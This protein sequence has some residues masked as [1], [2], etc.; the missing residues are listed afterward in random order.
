MAKRKEKQVRHLAALLAASMI[1]P[2]A[3]PAIRV[4]ADEPHIQGE[5]ATSSGDIRSE[6]YVEEDRKGE[7]D[8]NL[9]VSDI[10][11]KEWDGSD[12]VQC[13]IGLTGIRAGC[14]NVSLQNYTLR[15]EDSDVGTGKSVIVEKIILGGEDASHYHL[16]QEQYYFTSD[17][18]ITKRKLKLSG[19]VADRYY[20]EGNTDADINVKIENVAMTDYDSSKA[21]LIPGNL[22]VSVKAHFA[23]EHAGEGKKVTIDEIMLSGNHAK[24]YIVD[25]QFGELTGTIRKAGRDAPDLPY[26][27]LAITGTDTTMEWRFNAGGWSDCG[28]CIVLDGKGTYEVRYKETDDY[29][30]S[31]PFRLTLENSVKGMED[32]SFSFEEGYSPVK[33]YDGTVQAPSRVSWSGPAAGDQVELVSYTASYEQ[34]EVGEEILVS[35]TDPVFSGKDAD[36]YNTYFSG[37]TLAT[38]YGRITPR[39]IHV[40]VAATDKDYDGTRKANVYICGHTS[41]VGNENPDLTV[42]GEFTDADAGEGKAVTYGQVTLSGS[43]S[44]NY[45]IGKVAPARI[46]DGA[47]KELESLTATIRKA[48]QNAPDKALFSVKDG[49]LMGFTSDMEVL[50]PG[51]TEYTDCKGL[52]EIMISQGSSYLFRYKESENYKPG[53]T[54]TVSVGV[55]KTV[56]ITFDLNGA[57]VNGT[58]PTTATKT[59]GQMYGDILMDLTLADPDLEF[60]GWFTKRTGGVQVIPGDIC[61]R[62]EDFTLYAHVQEKANNR[63]K[64]EIAVSIFN[65]VYGNRISPQVSNVTGD[66]GSYTFYYKQAAEDD[67]AYTLEKPYRPGAYV[68]K[69]VA[70]KTND[71]DT[72]EATAEFQITKRILTATFTPKSRP[73][74]GLTSCEVEGN[75]SIA[76][77]IMSWDGRKDDVALSGTPSINFADKNVGNNKEVCLSGLSLTGSDADFYELHCET[78]TA[79]IT[80]YQLEYQE[81]RLDQEDRNAFS[82]TAGNKVYDQNTEAVIAAGLTKISGDDV[83]IK[84]LGRF[85]DP[86]AGTDKEVAVTS[87]TLEGA[88][89]ANYE[90]SYPASLVLKAIIYKAANENY[91]DISGTNPVMGKKNGTITGLTSAMEY[92]TDGGTLWN[93]CP[94]G[95]LAGLAAGEYRIRFSETQN[96][97]ASGV[98]IVVLK[99][100]ST[101][102]KEDKTQGQIKISID[103]LIYGETNTSPEVVNVAGDYSEYIFYYKPVGKEDEAYSVERPEIPGKYM[104]KA[105]AKETEK[106]KETEATEEFTIR[107]RN[108]PVTVVSSK[109]YDGTTDVN[110][111]DCNWEN[112]LQKDQESVGVDLSSAE[113]SYMDKYAGTEKELS[114]RGLRIIGEKADCYEI[115]EITG[116]GVI[117]KRELESEITADEKEYDGTRDAVLS[118]KLTNMVKGDEVTASGKALFESPLPGKEIPVSVTEIILEGKDAANYELK[119]NRKEI[120]GTIRN[121]VAEVKFDLNG[122]SSLTGVPSPIRIEAGS[123]YPALPYVVGTDSSKPFLGWFTAEGIH[124]KEG[125]PYQGEAVLYARFGV[126]SEGMIELSAKSYEYGEEPNIIVRILSGNYK[127]TDIQYRYRLKAN[128][129]WH[130]GLPKEPGEYRIQAIV[131]GNDGADG[132]SAE[133]DVLVTKRKITLKAESIEK[134]YDGNAKA[135]SV[136]QL[137]GILSEDKVKV[138]AD[139]VY[140][141]YKPGDR[142]VQVTSIKLTGPDASKYILSSNTYTFPGVIRKKVGSTVTVKGKNESLYGKHDG[143]IAG[144]SKEMEYRNVE[145]KTWITCPDGS[146]TGL[147]NGTYEIRMKETDISAPGSVQTVTIVSEKT[148]GMTVVQ[149]DGSTKTIGIPY[150][151]KIERPADPV[152]TGYSFAGWYKDK[153]LTQKWDFDHGIVTDHVTLY[154]KWI[155]RTSSS[156]S[157]SSSRSSG[158]SGGGSSK[159]VSS[160]PGAVSG[161]WEKDTAGHWR[162][163]GSHRYVNEWAYIANPYADT[164]KGQEGASW[165]HFGHDGIMDTGWFTD[166]DGRIY[167]LNPISD[168]TLG[169]MLTGWHWLRGQDGLLRCYYFEEKSNGYRGMLYQGTTTP[170]GYTVDVDGAWTVGGIVVTRE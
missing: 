95:E 139:A 26:S 73:Y 144:V 142:T 158:S 56:A 122:E 58:Y 3:V 145:N 132:I 21:S 130:S 23:D 76:G 149:P 55:T 7:Y 39:T 97:R 108:I 93:R 123:P 8:L 88:D 128:D 170:D 148:I 66:Y 47:L 65:L 119:E 81:T 2:Q 84:A 87:L 126:A 68:I 100:G 52:T 106:Y 74:N 41:F 50:L 45:V 71:Y 121:K 15:F 136:F 72:A 16:S 104:I 69:A 112:I 169:R 25:D 29:L 43:G 90:I 111:W 133:S 32:V 31:Q 99:D 113:V 77:G 153:T 53:A 162:F 147:P 118:I 161:K 107:K 63:K 167:Y 146:I 83:S 35:I 156:G 114:V 46:E 59:T 116:K 94:D 80:P 11:S 92:S 101:E 34:A 57:V 96:Y 163:S 89:A 155:K 125:D 82:L 18:E 38:S 75:V 24:N 91:P 30:A 51:N 36:K 67:S 129:E 6:T 44:E 117:R 160:K 140:D 135:D 61:D 10:K 60:I 4:F 42:T 134:E 28:N 131:A 70:M 64:G 138:L 13:R 152:K 127:E 157:S 86:N 9:V 12:A 154:P 115:G 165:F 27:N 37:K 49:K 102:E 150:G 40:H 143:E 22:S 166:H 159:A 85:A 79:D 5:K 19:T 151:Q 33:E 20:K 98:K 141:S 1:M 137:S 120:T 105:V 168:N 109:E 78:G 110:D 164:S 17:A 124:V 54:T 103:D 62:T 14:E 48:P